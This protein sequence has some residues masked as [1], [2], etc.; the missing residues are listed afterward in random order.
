M[1]LGNDGD[2]RKILAFC[3]SEQQIF[4]SVGR[5]VLE[6]DEIMELTHFY[7]RGN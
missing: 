4:L 5:R 3:T 7:R 1:Y 2:P 6:D